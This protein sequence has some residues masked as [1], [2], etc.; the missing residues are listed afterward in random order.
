MLSGPGVPEAPRNI[1]AECRA[2]SSAFISWEEGVNN[3]AAITEYRLEWS[4][5]EN[6]SFM[7]LYCGTSC[8]YEAK[9][10]TPVTHYFFRVQVNSIRVCASQ[11]QRIVCA[12]LGSEHRWSWPVQSV[13]ILCHTGNS[14][15]D[16]YIRESPF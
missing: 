8:T 7:Q 10:L 3:G 11:L 4:R 16:R 2:S 6:D 15:G 13:S 14:T 9:G 12:C 5:K 1:S